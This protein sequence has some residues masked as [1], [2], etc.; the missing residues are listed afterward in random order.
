MAKSKIHTKAG[1]QPK[2][3]VGKKISFRRKNG[4]MV[5][6]NLNP[7]QNIKGK[8]YLEFQLAYNACTNKPYST[9]NSE[10]AQL[11]KPQAFAYGP[12]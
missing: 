3:A 11:M 8:G 4:K 7:K 1:A 5:N 10:Y 9:D 2:G 6:F 12:I